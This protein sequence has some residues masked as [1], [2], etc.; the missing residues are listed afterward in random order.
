MQ[1]HTVEHKRVGQAVAKSTCAH[2]LTM[3]ELRAKAVA[4][5]PVTPAWEPPRMY[6]PTREQ[7]GRC[8]AGLDLLWQLNKLV[9]ELE[10]MLEDMPVPLYSNVVRGEIG[11]LWHELETQIQ[12]YRLLERQQ[13]TSVR[14]HFDKPLADLPFLRTTQHRV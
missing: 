9:I 14:M 3:L 7:V 8:E 6:R 12:R 11:R 5:E 2:I 13:S 4:P 10:S 1:Q